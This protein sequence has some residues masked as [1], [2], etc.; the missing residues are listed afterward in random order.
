MQRRILVIGSEGQIGTELMLAIQNRWPESF[1]LG[2]DLMQKN[3]GHWEFV[4]MDARDAEGLIDIVRQFEIDTVYLMAAMLS[5]RGEQMPDEAWDLNMGSLLNV[6]K[7]A[8]DG[9][10]KQ[11]FWPSSIAVFGPTTPKNPASQE[12]ICA[13]TTVYGIS[14][15]AGELW[16]Q[17][18]NLKYG[19]DVRSIRYPGLISYGTVPGGGTTDYAVEIFYNAVE[20]KNYTCFLEPHTRLP[21]M[22]MPDAIK[23]T[24]EL[25]EAPQSCLSTRM[26][27]NIAAFS[28]TPHELAL[29]IKKFI[30]EFEIQ[31]KP[32][33]RQKIAESWPQVIDDTQARIDW[34][35]SPEFDFEEMVK[36]MLREIKQN[37][38]A[39]KSV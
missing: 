4:P 21:M 3:H 7:L 32:D 35:W 22:F 29:C 1:I 9:R 36:I 13:P 18:Y 17:W 26:A 30:T 11:I 38:A 39:E 28:F 37:R 25:M 10:I 34:H 2:A 15:Y 23:A 14:K 8:R 27:Y 6:L 31:Y 19:V 16:C 24:L 20:K 33:F 12:T 5:A